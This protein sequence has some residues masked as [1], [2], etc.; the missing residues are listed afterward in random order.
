L[1]DIKA[2]KFSPL[3]LRHGEESYFIDLI[4]DALDSS[5]LTEAEKGFNYSLFY[6]KDLPDAGPVAQAARRFPMMSDHQLVIVREA[7]EIKNYETKNP[8]LPPTCDARKGRG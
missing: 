3:Y 7:Q 1:A 6:G 5:V 4:A 2:K 8:N